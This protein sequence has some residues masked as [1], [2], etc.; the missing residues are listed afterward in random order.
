MN[1]QI[2]L[3]TVPD[4]D[5]P[6]PDISAFGKLVG[7]NFTYGSSVEYHCNDGYY[8]SRETT[9]ISLEC[10]DTGI[11]EPVPTMIQCIRKIYRCSW[12]PTKVMLSL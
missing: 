11:W 7:N 9:S 1:A 10:T 2:L 6:A 3:Q 5:C 8:V 12:E 4:V